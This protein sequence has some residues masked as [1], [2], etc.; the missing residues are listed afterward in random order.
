MV[1]AISLP[2]LLAHACPLARAPTCQSSM[3]PRPCLGLGRLGSVCGA[4]GRRR[5]AGDASY[6]GPCPAASKHARRH[7]LPHGAWHLSNSQWRFKSNAQ[8]P[9]HDAAP[10]DGAPSGLSWSVLRCDFIK[11]GS[12]GLRASGWRPT[13]PAA[14]AIFDDPVYAPCEGKVVGALDGQPDMA[15]PK[16]DTS[17]LEGNHVLIQ[18]GNFAVLLAHLRNGA[19]AA[20]SI[21]Q[22]IRRWRP[23]HW[24]D[25]PLEE[26]SRWYSPAIRGWMNYYCCF[27]RS[28]FKVIADHLDDVL[29]RWDMRK[30]KRLRGHKTRAREQLEVKLLR[31]TRPNIDLVR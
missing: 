18:C 22:T 25:V 15:V 16:M 10:K 9:L 11:I 21:R 30:Y 12:L 29:V 28:T 20:T 2:G 19:N 23:S 31:L 3:A 24:S 5:T 17:K 27:Q 7:P 13:D 6:T 1:D 26:L 14:Y 8:R 4:R